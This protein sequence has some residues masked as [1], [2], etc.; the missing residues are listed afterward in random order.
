M[1]K[2]LGLLLL[3]G[4]LVGCGSSGSSSSSPS[5]T[6]NWQIT[7]NSTAF[8]A[9]GTGSGAVQQ[10]G[11]SVTGTLTLSGTPCATTA[12]LSGSIS[13]T[14]VTLQLEEGDQ[15]VN[16]RGTANSGLTSMSGS[17]TAPSGGCTNGDFGTWSA[18][19][20]S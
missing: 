6:G 16:L 17:Y 19:K 11:S 5:L 10:N 4:C 9:T 14:T 2:I 13:G 18:T 8:G 15:L 7:I 3:C 20:T 1:K 12:S